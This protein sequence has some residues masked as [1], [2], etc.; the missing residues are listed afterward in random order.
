MSK[1]SEYGIWQ[2]MK[3]RCF[4]EKDAHF[5]NYGGRGITVCDKWKNDFMSFYNYVGPRPSNDYS[6]D[7]INVDGNYEPGNVRWATRKLQNSN[8]RLYVN[9][10]SIPTDQLIEELKRRGETSCS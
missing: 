10:Q 1:T 2:T 8:R 5:K 3:D 7:R 4:R 6:L 9:L